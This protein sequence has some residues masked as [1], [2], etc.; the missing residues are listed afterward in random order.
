MRG[1]NLIQHSSHGSESKRAEWQ[2]FS[3][4]WLYWMS[5]ILH[6]YSI[7][8]L[9]TDLIPN[10]FKEDWLSIYLLFRCSFTVMLLYAVAPGSSLSW[11]NCEKWLRWLEMANNMRAVMKGNWYA[12]HPKG[13]LIRNRNHANILIAEPTL[14]TR[15]AYCYH[16]I[17]LVKHIWSLK[18]AGFATFLCFFVHFFTR[19]IW[20]WCRLF[21]LWVL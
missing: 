19:W 18:C 9:Q 13:N 4:V 12:Q 6:R 20:F 5:L 14:T 21:T 2:V 8:S 11:Y 3:W 16:V 17:S 10:S 15:A 7:F 1:W